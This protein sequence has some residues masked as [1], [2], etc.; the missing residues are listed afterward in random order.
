MRNLNAALAAIVMSTAFALAANASPNLVQ[1]GGFE[2]TSLSNPGGTVCAHGGT[3]CVSRVANW[4]SQCNPNIGVCD[5]NSLI[6]LVSSGSNGSGFNNGNALWGP[7]A[8]SPAGGNF[9]AGDGDPYY[10]TPIWQ[11]VG[12][13]TIG[14]HY[15]ISFYQGAAQQHGLSGATTERWQVTFG[16]ATQ[17]STLINNPSHGVQPWSLQTL[18]FIA[19]SGTQVLNF[20]AVG[21]PSGY[22]PISLLDG[23]SVTAVAGGAPEPAAWMIMLA[24]FGLFGLAARRRRATA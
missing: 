18:D 15:T 21:T 14:Q 8:D 16:G 4:S 5:H 24:G 1:N 2:T 23:V 9:I 11:S 7:V 20:L 19:T 10:A 13:L 6:D 12:G 3:T 22:P 17:L